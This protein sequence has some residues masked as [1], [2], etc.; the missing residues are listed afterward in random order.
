MQQGVA[1][2]PQDVEQQADACAARCGSR[3]LEA[4]VVRARRRRDGP[5][6]AAGSDGGRHGG[7]DGGLLRG[8]QSHRRGADHT[9]V[10]H[11][12]VRP[13]RARQHLTGAAVDVLP[14]LHLAVQYH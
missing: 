5:P 2:S 10:R 11:A 1:R 4:L 13:T 6:L 7:H 12:P 14:L 3:E 8:C 9:G